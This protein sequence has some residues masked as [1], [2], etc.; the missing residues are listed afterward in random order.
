MMANYVKAWQFIYSLYCGKC[1]VWALQHF[2][3]GSGNQEQLT[4]FVAHNPL[5]K[6]CE[7][8]EVICQETIDVQQ[9]MVLLLT[10]LQSLG[11]YG[12]Q[13]QGMPRT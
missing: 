6:V 11:E 12:L 7:K 9:C 2:C 1:L 8:S 4:C 13:I 10:T 3:A 5:C